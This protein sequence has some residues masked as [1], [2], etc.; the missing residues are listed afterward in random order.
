[1]P[2]S[3]IRVTVTCKEDLYESIC[4]KAAEEG[5]S[6]SNLFIHAASLYISPTSG[7]SKSA[8]KVRQGAV[9]KHQPDAHVMPDEYDLSDIDLD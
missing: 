5:R 8:S 4:A 2:S 9:K 1:M 3:S 6:V 7:S